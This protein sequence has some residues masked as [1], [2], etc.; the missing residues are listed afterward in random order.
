LQAPMTGDAPGNCQKRVCDLAGVVKVVA[1]TADIDDDM[2]PCTTD[3][4]TVEGVVEH[5]PIGPGGTSPCPRP[6][7]CANLHRP[8]A[9]KCVA[10]NVATQ[11]TDC[12]SKICQNNTCVPATCADTVK[13]GS[14]SDIDCGGKDCAGCDDGKTCLAPGD[15]ASGVCTGGKCAPP[16]CD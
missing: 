3:T 4:C 9:G 13:N 2:K 5:K 10:C 6:Q 8:H 15:C 16:A 12:P 7:I 11:T 14:E 1:D